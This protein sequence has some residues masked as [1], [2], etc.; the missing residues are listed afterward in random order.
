MDDLI[1]RESVGDKV[2]YV[3]L[4]WSDERTHVE[5]RKALEGTLGAS[6]LRCKYWVYGTRIQ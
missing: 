2:L 3:E 6:E 5:M 4:V 1:P